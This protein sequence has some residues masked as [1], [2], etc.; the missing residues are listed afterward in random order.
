M[1]LRLLVKG[2]QVLKHKTRHGSDP[3]TGQEM[4]QELDAA[5]EAAAAVK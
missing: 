3:D 2:L 4:L 5:G 1:G